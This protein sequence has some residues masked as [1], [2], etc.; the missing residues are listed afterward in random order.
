MAR[1]D[2]LTELVLKRRDFL[3]ALA[4]RPRAKPDLVEATETSRSTVDRAIDALEAR[5]LV[6]REDGTYRLTFTGRYALSEFDAYTSRLDA[7]VDAHDVLGDLGPEASVDPAALV[8][9]TVQTAPSYPNDVAFH[10]VI[11]LVRAGDRV[12]AVGPALPP[13]YVDDVRQSIEE[14]ELELEL[15]VTPTVVD[16]LDRR[17]CHGLRDLVGRDEVGCYDLDECVPYALWIVESGDGTDAGLVVYTD[18]GV[19]GVVRNDTDAMAEWAAATFLEYREAAA[20]CDSFSR[21]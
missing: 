13:R 8:G 21:V 15:V 16:M 10:D 17:G 4:D 11:E 14:N 5:G 18:T 19:K 9:A 12:R 1:E 20:P 3:Q 2:S 6:A 7:L